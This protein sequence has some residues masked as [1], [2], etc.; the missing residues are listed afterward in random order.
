LKK[1]DGIKKNK[2]KQFNILEYL[3]GFRKYDEDG[4]KVD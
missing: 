1:E 4:N 3:I 2:K